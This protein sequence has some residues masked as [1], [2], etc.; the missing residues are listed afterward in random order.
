MPATADNASCDYLDLQVNGYA[1]VD[2]NGDDLTAES[3]HHACEALRRD[4]NA[5]V[6]A[7]IITDR[8]DVM[9]RRLAKLVQLRQQ[10]ELAKQLIVGLHIEGPFINETP[11]YRG[12][13]P[14]DAIHPANG[15]EMRQLLEAG[16]GLTKL[17]TLAP[18]SDP[19]LAVTKMLAS[20]GI[21]VSAGHCDPTLD[22]LD[23][24]I[25]AGLSMWTHLGNGC[26]M[27]M[28][29]HDNVV[30]RALSRADRLWLC[31]IADGVHVPFAAL[32]NYLKLAGE[33]AIVVTDAMA[34]AS[35][36]PGRHR[37]GR[38]EVDVSED[39]AAWAPD[40]SHLVGSALTMNQAADNL[41]RALGASDQQIQQWTCSN[42]RLALGD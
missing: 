27:Q 13:H 33:R 39:L 26:P 2:F 4:G 41:R 16:G 32:G 28:H 11:G 23:A 17:V 8:I 3:L 30:Q 38:W 21:I 40:R 6:L 12:A 10:D 22:Q 1:G 31:F 29:R 5:G 20:Q 18:E 19:A 15:D 36:G 7:T 14:V 25:E 35:L 37:L 34:A 24:A 42:P 9:C